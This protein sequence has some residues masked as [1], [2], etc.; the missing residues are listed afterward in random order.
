L[1]PLIGSIAV[2]ALLGLVLAL[3]HPRSAPGEGPAVLAIEVIEAP[4]P[5]QQPAKQVRH[6]KGD[7]P[8]F[9][10]SGA[11]KG[12][13]PHFRSRADDPRGEITIEREAGEKTGDGPGYS[14]QETGDGPGYSGVGNGGDG[15]GRGAAGSREMPAVP[16]VIA[17]EE[18]VSKARPARL[19]YPRRNR[20]VEEGETF[21][22]R[23]TI[24]AE[25]YVVGAR[26][27]RGFGGRRDEQAA[28]LIFKFRY[29]PALDDDGRPV[30][31]T[32]D[33]N[34]LVE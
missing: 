16:P 31:S 26:L 29:A 8:H 9:R 12:D 3:L 32:L 7:G 15:L 34:F 11:K 22:A 25:G 10:L 13:G 5:P 24:D 4:T 2:H 17:H 19:V 14:G 23:V 1:R 30:R 21:V 27:V 18:R 28:S 33:Q 6:G 20:E